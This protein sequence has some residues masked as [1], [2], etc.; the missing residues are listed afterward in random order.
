MQVYSAGLIV[1]VFWMLCVLK[2]RSYAVALV[3]ALLPFGMLNVF[4]LGGFSFVADDF[5]AAACVGLFT[6]YFI[7]VTPQG[8]SIQCPVFC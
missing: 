5:V 7:L 8:A 3:G 4:R 1:I 6:L 2:H